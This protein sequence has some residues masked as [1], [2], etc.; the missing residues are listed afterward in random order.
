M[1]RDTDCKIR[2][3]NGAGGPKKSRGKGQVVV[4]KKTVELGIMRVQIMESVHLGIRLLQG[5]IQE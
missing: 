1:L 3:V 5:T 2:H 4:G